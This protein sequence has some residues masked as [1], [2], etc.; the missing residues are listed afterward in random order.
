MSKLDR[1]P[2]EEMRGC[3]PADLCR[4]VATYVLEDPDLPE[5]DRL[6]AAGIL[7]ALDGASHDAYLTVIPVDGRTLISAANAEA[8][9]LW[10]KYGEEEHRTGP[11]KRTIAQEGA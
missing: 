4:Q 11:G 2:L 7:G 3:Y 5:E 6:C 10:Q 8:E 1:D 9:R